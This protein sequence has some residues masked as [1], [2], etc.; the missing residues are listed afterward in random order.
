[1]VAMC[2]SE[3]ATLLDEE[4]RGSVVV[5]IPV[6]SEPGKKPESA[7]TSWRLK[8]IILLAVTAQNTCYALVRRYSRGHLREQYS[9]SSAL[10]LPL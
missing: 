4:K 1:M 5:F 2:S 10:H 7:S 9:A 3:K 6:P 8:L